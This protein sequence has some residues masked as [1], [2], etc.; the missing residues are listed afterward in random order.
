MK[1]TNAR[2]LVAELDRTVHTVVDCK[3][4]CIKKDGCAGFDYVRKKNDCWLHTSVTMRKLES[5]HT[6]DN[7]RGTTA[8]RFNL[9]CIDGIQTVCKLEGRYELVHNS[10]GPNDT[11]EHLSL[12]TVLSR[13]CRI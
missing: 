5:K 13:A 1:T 8:A 6:T 11:I 7:Y 10:I 9:M 4:A 3:R 12:A 2:G